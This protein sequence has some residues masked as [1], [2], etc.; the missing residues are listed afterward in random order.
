[1]TGLELEPYTFRLVDGRL[2]TI[3]GF[4]EP[5][6]R[7]RAERECSIHSR[8][9]S[10]QPGVPAQECTCQRPSVTELGEA[11]VAVCVWC[12]GRVPWWRPTQEGSETRGQR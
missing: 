1:M 2:F 11:R 5:D 6:A 12:A 8:V 9:M 4:N 10:C 7:R 3:L